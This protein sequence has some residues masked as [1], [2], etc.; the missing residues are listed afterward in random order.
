ME[1]KKIKAWAVYSE[2]Y[3]DISNVIFPSKR[4]AQDYMRQELYHRDPLIMKE[5][6]ALAKKSKSIVHITITYTLPKKRKT[7]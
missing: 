3:G 1:T 2:F 4:M 6:I 7:K 5:A